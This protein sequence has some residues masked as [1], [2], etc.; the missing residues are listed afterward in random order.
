M[1]VQ[2]FKINKKNC[3]LRPTTATADETFSTTYLGTIL[4]ILSAIENADCN[5]GYDMLYCIYYTLMAYIFIFNDLL[6]GFFV[7]CW[8]IIFLHYVIILLW[9][10]IKYYFMYYVICY[11]PIAHIIHKK[12]HFSQMPNQINVPFIQQVWRS[13]IYYNSRTILWHYTATVFL[14]V[15]IPNI[16]TCHFYAKCF[17]FLLSKGVVNETKNKNPC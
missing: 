7:N 10:Y 9:F 14:S 2:N 4:N 12:N 16:T 17:Q 15:I 6:L 8:C 1:L 3:L 13:V 11:V 5:N